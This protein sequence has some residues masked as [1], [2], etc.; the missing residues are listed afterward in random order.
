MRAGLPIELHPDVGGVKPMHG[1]RLL[2][3]S[4]LAL[5]GLCVALPLAYAVH[6]ATPAPRI[7]R[8]V[9]IGSVV[10]G[11]YEFTADW[12]TYNADNWRNILRE[13]VGRAAVN[14]LE[15]GSF[16]GRSAIWF[17]ENVLTH[18]SA[19]L[20]CI[21][22]FHD[23]GDRS[24]EQRFDRNIALTGVGSKVVKRKGFSQHVLRS[25]PVDSFDFIYVDG[26]H[27]AID[28][29]TDAVLSWGLLRRGGIIIFD[30]YELDS[31][32]DLAQDGKPRL[33]IDAWLSVH[34]PYLTVLHD[35]YQLAVRR[36]R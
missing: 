16:E 36:D 17:L 10:H 34:R 19:R 9:E 33:A 2:V 26:S 8:P 3:V 31:R 32:G 28:V 7:S 21:D 30:D 1:G 22:P 23:E 14:A 24:Y 35:E 15:I 20:T 4:W 6:R 25:L 12:V 13:Y 18:P 27:A 29:L 11:R 5:L